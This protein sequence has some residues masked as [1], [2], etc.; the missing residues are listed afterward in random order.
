MADGSDQ[1]NSANDLFTSAMST[2]SRATAGQFFFYV[3]RIGGPMSVRLICFTGLALFIGFVGSLYVA[4]QG[5]A[6]DAQAILNSMSYLTP[7]VGTWTAVAEFRQK[8]GTLAYDVGTYKIFSVL[9]GTYLE[10][11]VELHDK[12][13]PSKHH[14]F[15]TF[16]TYN[17]VTKKY[18]STYFYSR[19]ALRVT[20]TGEYDPKTKEFRTT[21]F[22]PLEDGL[23]DENVR[24]ITRIRDRDKIVYEHYSRYSNERAERMN[25]VITLTRVP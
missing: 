5:R 21:A 11:E 10:W 15:L 13:D 16:V 7:M 20:E 1:K 19:W 23:H 25:V 18:D 4:A 17:P 9:A 14:S 22:I 6:D 12:D 8:D 3:C 24:T 2:Q